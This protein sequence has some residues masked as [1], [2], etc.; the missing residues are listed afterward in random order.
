[1]NLYGF[2][3]NDSVNHRDDLG[4][5]IEESD[6]NVDTF[7]LNPAVLDR[8]TAALIRLDKWV[9][10]FKQ[11][12]ETIGGIKMYVLELGGELELSGYYNRLRGLPSSSTLTHER[13]HVRIYQDNW[14]S[15][16]SEVNGYEQ[17]YC[18][19]ECRDAAVDIYKNTNG[20][21]VQYSERDHAEFHIREGQNVESERDAV[22]KAEQK[23]DSYRKNL[24]KA[25]QAYRDADCPVIYSSN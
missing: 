22:N 3:G 15:F 8:G 9:A 4:L 13:E 2:V 19:E 23:I 10:Y 5:A 24:D 1:M 11:S 12:E 7:A 25:K 21:Y 18:K 6:Y 16:A 14:N 20:L 17:K